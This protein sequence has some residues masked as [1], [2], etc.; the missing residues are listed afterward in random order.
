MQ[1]GFNEN[2]VREVLWIFNGN[3]EMA[4]QALF[5]HVED[6]LETRNRP[7]QNHKTSKRVKVDQPRPPL[8]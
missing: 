3:S 6:E 2:Q 7:K 5:Q 4:A 1:L 8:S